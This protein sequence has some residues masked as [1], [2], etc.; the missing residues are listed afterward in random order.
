[1]FPSANLVAFV[2]TEDLIKA[3]ETQLGDKDPAYLCISYDTDLLAL[4]D[5]FGYCKSY[6][7]YARRAPNVTLE[8][9]TK[10]VNI[11]P[12]RIAQ[13]PSNVIIAWTLS[14]DYVTDRYEHGT[15]RLK[16]RLKASAEARTL[17]WRVRVCIDPILK[18]ADW[19]A[20]YSE[21][22]A[23]MFQGLDGNAL[24]DVSLGVFRIASGYLRAM[25][26]SSAS[27]TIAHY[28]YTVSN[29]SAS[30][31]DCERLEMLE[32]LTDELSKHLP[33]EKICPVPWQL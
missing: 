10:S 26:E 32:H 20:H 30:Y 21:L 12:L 2:N 17:G 24:Y 8:I 15:P 3:A 33:K 18:V 13:P 7:D 23:V 16:A 19:R 5:L 22:V 4:E 14:P 11:K 9:R 27:N 28:P 25:R 6:I 1:M 31:S 29:Q